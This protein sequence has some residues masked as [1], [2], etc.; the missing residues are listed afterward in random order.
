MAKPLRRSG[1]R[2]MVT[3]DFNLQFLK[4]KIFGKDGLYYV[5]LGWLSALIGFGKARDTYFD[6]LE[7]GLLTAKKVRE[8]RGVQADV[9]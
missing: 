2:I 1:P 7:L 3:I 6:T 5:H 4:P 9:R 8:Q